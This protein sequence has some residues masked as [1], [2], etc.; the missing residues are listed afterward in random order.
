MVLL[1]ALGAGQQGSAGRVLE[2]FADAL[3]GLGGALEVVLGTDLLLHRHTLQAMWSDTGI[4]TQNDSPSRSATAQ[5]REWQLSR[6]RR[7][8]CSSG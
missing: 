3:A 2:D 6:R 5:A 8:A 1:A 4:Q 7:V